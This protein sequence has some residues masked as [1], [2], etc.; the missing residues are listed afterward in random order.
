MNEVQRLAV[1]K[2]L[3]I[4]F[5]SA[6]RQFRLQRQQPVDAE[7]G[8]V[9]IARFRAALETTISALL[10]KQKVPDLIARFAQQLRRQPRDLQH[11]QSQTHGASGQTAEKFSSLCLAVNPTNLRVRFGQGCIK[12]LDFSLSSIRWRRGLG[13]GGAFYW[14]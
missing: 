3:Q 5:N 6:H 4:A 8:V 7:D 14:F 11:L 9:Q 2:G 1:A 10:A 12:L 13:R